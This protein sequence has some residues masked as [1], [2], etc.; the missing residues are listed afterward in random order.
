MSIKID[1]LGIP[2]FDS[3]EVIELLYRG[4]TDQIEKIVIEN[5]NETLQFKE[6][7][8]EK[9]GTALN[10]YQKYDI[11]LETFDS[12]CQDVWLMPQDYIDIDVE[13][14]L[15]NKCNDDT[16]KINRVKLE[17]AEYRSK[18]MYNILRFMIFLVDFMKDNNIIWGVG[19]GSS[20][21]S[22]V[23]Y[24]IGIHKVDSILYDLDFYEFMK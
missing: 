13:E 12:I 22:Y 3:Q 15:F 9:T 20:V 21:A 11:D 1:D 16:E 2:I 18:N 24:L 17:L 4:R 23:L 19:R 6:H 14:F 7:L 8:H 5:T 10:L